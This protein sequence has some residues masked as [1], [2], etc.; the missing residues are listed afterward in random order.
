VLIV[1]GRVQCRAEQRDELIAHLH[2]FVRRLPDL[3]SARPEVAIHEVAA[4]RPFPH[5]VR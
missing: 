1:I 3:I 4:T 5:V 2:E